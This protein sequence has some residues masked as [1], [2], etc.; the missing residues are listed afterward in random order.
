MINCW[1]VRAPGDGIWIICPR[2][3]RSQ[4]LWTGLNRYVMS[5]DA[6]VAAYITHVLYRL[7]LA[8]HFTSGFHSVLI[9]CEW[10]ITYTVLRYNRQKSWS[11]KVLGNTIWAG[12]LFKQSLWLQA[13]VLDDFLSKFQLWNNNAVDWDM[14]KQHMPLDAY[15]I[16]SH[17]L[18]SNC[19]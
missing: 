10:I 8:E 3:H 7:L 6:A 14:W 18:Y 5:P 9:L 17:Y 1:A 13:F 16:H 11:I 2:A 4:W 12:W 19:R 15:G